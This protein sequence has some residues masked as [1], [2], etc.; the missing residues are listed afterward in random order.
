MA[1]CAKSSECRHAGLLCRGGRNI[2]NDKRAGA[3]MVTVGSAMKMPHGSKFPPSRSGSLKVYMAGLLRSLFRGQQH[4]SGWIFHGAFAALARGPR[5]GATDQDAVALLKW[6]E[7]YWNRQMPSSF[8][9]HSRM[10]ANF[11]STKFRLETR[12]RRLYCSLTY[13]LATQSKKLGRS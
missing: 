7:T 13:V 11:A 12:N 8:A 5:R 10:F 3:P 9:G 2:V 1:T 4:S 6:A